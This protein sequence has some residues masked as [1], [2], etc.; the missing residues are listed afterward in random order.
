MTTAVYHRLD[1]YSAVDRDIPINIETQKC[2]FHLKHIPPLDSNSLSTA[3]N[4]T[5]DLNMTRLFVK[6]ASWP[7]N[8][9]IES[10]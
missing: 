3:L 5:L 8:R 10:H 6:Y 1:R 4:P 2:D 9:A 7:L